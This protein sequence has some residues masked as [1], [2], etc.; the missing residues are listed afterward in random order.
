MSAVTPPA[1]QETPERPLRAAALATA[2]VVWAVSLGYVL[3]ALYYPARPMI[4]PVAAP[5]SVPSCCGTGDGPHAGGRG[6][7]HCG[8]LNNNG[9][10]DMPCSACC[11]PPPCKGSPSGLAPV[12]S[13]EGGRP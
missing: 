12:V 11:K 3:H 9:D 13:S 6:S 10:C 2:A 1:R 7:G 8:C 4:T 5:S